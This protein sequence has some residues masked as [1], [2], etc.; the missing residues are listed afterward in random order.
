MKNI[1]TI[2]S[3]LILLFFDGGVT[4]AQWIQSDGPYAG[5]VKCLA[6]DGS[7]I[8]AG[9]DNG[10]V[11]YSSDGGKNWQAANI[12]L[13]N[14][15][16]AS[17]LSLGND[18]YAGTFGA[19]GAGVFISTNDGENWVSGG[20]VLANLNITSLTSIDTNI[21]AGTTMGLY[22]S[23]EADSN[24]ISILPNTYIKDLAVE[25]ST[26]IVVTEYQIFKS[27]N[28][29]ANWTEIDS[30]LNGS[31]LNTIAVS[32]NNMFVGV[33]YPA[34]VPVG[35]SGNQIPGGIFRTTNGGENWA[36]VDS[37]LI[38]TGVSALTLSGSN[39]YAGTTNNIFISTDDGKN[40][41]AMNSRLPVIN[42]LKINGSTIFAGTLEGVYTSTIGDTTWNFSNNG[43]INFSVN[44]FGTFGTKLFAGTDNILSSTD[45]GGSWT[46]RDSSN[47][48]ISS[49]AAE[50]SKLFA[51]QEYP[52]G[53]YSSTNNGSTWTLSD[54]N[55]KN[56][57][58]SCLTASGNTIFAG[59]KNGNG[60]LRSTDNGVTW[61]AANS[62]LT[63]KFIFSLAV[64]TGNSGTAYIF[65]GT[66]NGGVF[67]STDNGL[68]WSLPGSD[69]SDRIVFSLAV[70]GKNLFAGTNGGIYLSTDNGG[71]W[72]ISGPSNIFVSS[73]ALNGT[74]IFVSYIRT[75]VTYGGVLLSTDEGKSWTSVNTG[76]TNTDVSSLAVND[77]YI[78]AGTSGSGIWRRP[79]SD[80][81][82]NV[83]VSNKKIPVSFALYQNYP[84]PFNPS[85]TIKYQIPKPGLVQL[86]VY[87]ILGREV[88]A[89]VNEYQTAGVHSIQFSSDNK[90]QTTNYKQLSSGI[91]FYRLKAGGFAE[92]KKLLLLK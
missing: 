2:I 22:R 39:I 5:S 61:N 53:L 89:L 66:Q 28:L 86:K 67:R 13:Y 14:N 75:A 40:W 55:I 90:L 74:N 19:Y 37:Q 64:S 10:G 8:F 43:I 29:G 3:V 51:G 65:A 33:S 7:K 85:T 18:I 31:I 15:N 12:G 6:I 72:N 26:L 47:S 49:F 79:L 42:A 58:V 46:I 84:N 36:V 24:W 44:S 83:S 1:F 20:S 73:I 60:V 71:S 87:D 41:K 45:N 48:F 62:G 38:N 78:Y 59:D 57:N 91:Y 35:I 11:F 70:D 9:T 54:T 56:F 16:I 30:G 76:L 81:L 82:T 21:F 80:F 88:A 92:T 27:D 69:L 50:G 52:G 25:G 68:S 23:T 32:G 77:T 34:A 17:L 63:N 4:K